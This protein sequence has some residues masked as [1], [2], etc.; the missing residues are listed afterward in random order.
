VLA[1]QGNIMHFSVP[2]GCA[3]SPNGR[4]LFQPFDP[5]PPTPSRHDTVQRFAAGVERALS[6]GGRFLVYRGT[7]GPC[8][9]MDLELGTE[10]ASYMPLNGETI[11]AISP[12][13][14]LV[15]SSFA[16]GRMLIR[17]PR[18]ANI[19]FMTGTHSNRVTAV[20]FS[21]AGNMLATAGCD[22]WLK[23]WDL[24]GL[25]LVAQAAMPGLTHFEGPKALAF[26]RDGKAVA[27]GENSGPV[28]V[29]D[30]EPVKP[31]R[32]METPFPG[33][34]ARGLAFSPNGRLLAACGFTEQAALFDPSSGRL[35]TTIGDGGFTQFELAEFTPDNRRLVL[36]SDGAFT[37]WDLQSKRNV[38]S[39]YVTGDAAIDQLRLDPSGDRLAITVLDSCQIYSAPRVE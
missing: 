37:F 4:V 32:L 35:I 27:C 30:L 25:R 5:R 3:T 36:T 26:A 34:F 20:E 38:L 31:P 18:L 16:D 12:G 7:N 10:I 24:G 22:G 8:R 29:M 11:G 19:R 17:E 39:V 28:L 14:Q 13:G 21:P 6:V 2:R 23:V 9:I 15:A 1:T 33:W